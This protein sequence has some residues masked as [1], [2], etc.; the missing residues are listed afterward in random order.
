MRRIPGIILAACLAAAWAGA[1]SGGIA[2]PGFDALTFAAGATEQDA[3]LF[4]PAENECLFKITLALEDGTTLWESG[5]IR[6]GGSVTKLTLSR[7][8]DAGTYPAALRC[9]CYS[10]RDGTPLNGAEIKLR[11]EVK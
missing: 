5:P 10:L 8:L 11:I 2:I 4:N 9:S 6:P 1:A 3:E 7:P